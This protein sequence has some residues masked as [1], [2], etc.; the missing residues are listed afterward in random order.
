MR[1]FL[2]SLLQA[3]GL[4]AALSCVR[5]RA[6]QWHADA[7]HLLLKEWLCVLRRQLRRYQPET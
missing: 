7:A 3:C 4:C 5:A 6:E 2:I 1:P